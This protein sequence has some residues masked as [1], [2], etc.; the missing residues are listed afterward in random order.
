MMADPRY[1]NGIYAGFSPLQKRQNIAKQ[2]NASPF[3]HGWQPIDKLADGRRIWQLEN[4]PAV[5]MHRIAQDDKARCGNEEWIVFISGRPY[6]G[7][8]GDLDEITAD[9]LAVIAEPKAA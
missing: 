1:R 8:S 3:M 7:Y 9:V 2:V 4:C 5:T 6:A